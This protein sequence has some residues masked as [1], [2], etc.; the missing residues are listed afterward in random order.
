MA[1][2]RFVI[3]AVLAVVT[4][5]V[6]GYSSYMVFKMFQEKYFLETPAE[7][8]GKDVLFSVEKGATFSVVARD[9]KR[10]GVITDTRRFLKLAQQKGKANS[11]RAGK[12]MLNT[13][14]IPEKV[15][16]VLTTTA[17]IMKRFSVREGLN[18]WQTAAKVEASKLGTAKGFE[19]AVFDK[20][21]LAKYGIKADSAEGF[22]FPETY[23]FTQPDR[24]R[25]RF[26]AEIMIKQFFDNV[27]KV[28]PDK[29]PSWDELWRTVVLASL[30]EK[31]T[32]DGSERRRIAGVF[33]NRL[34]RRM[35][36]QADPTVIYGLGKAFDGNVKRSHLRDKN[37]PYNTYT[38][39]G[40][41][42][43]PICS[44]GLE[45]LRAAA[46][47]EDHRYLY[48]VAKG[49]GTHYFSTNLREHNDAVVRYQ[50]RRNRKTYRS[51]KQ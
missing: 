17:G 1:T 48:F 35:L 18:W 40:L 38:H 43:G 28:W 11:I 8:P 39:I 22:L 26:L 42:P 7:T 16:T 29:A 41:P 36:L 12:F 44:P 5:L 50:L 32:G 37:N 9:L 27:R 2:K 14:W 49:D 24:D 15:L 33:H 3:P 25:E 19:A 34:K 45:S 10:L 47:P 46:N 6:M 31:E 4:I 21:L 51:T 23:L 13:G 20:A 30:V